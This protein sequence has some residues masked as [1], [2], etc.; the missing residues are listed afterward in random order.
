MAMIGSLR[1]IA[2]EEARLNSVFDR[3]TWE[4]RRQW[5]EHSSPTKVAKGSNPYRSQCVEFVLSSCRFSKRFFSDYSAF[6]LFVFSVYY[7][8]FSDHFK[9]EFNWDYMPKEPPR[10]C[11]S[12]LK[13]NKYLYF[14]FNSYSYGLTWIDVLPQYLKIVISVW[15]G[16]FMPEA[17]RM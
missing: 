2:M 3:V 14:I 10:G 8:F 12:A 4:W 7:F 16:L 5:W 13:S 1:K 15:S 17:K 11:A 9:F 6:A